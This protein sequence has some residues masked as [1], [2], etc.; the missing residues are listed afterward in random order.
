MSRLTLNIDDVI[1]RFKNTSRSNCKQEWEVGT[2]FHCNFIIIISHPSKPFIPMNK[3]TK[4]IF[5]FL[6]PMYVKYR[7]LIFTCNDV[8]FGWKIW[9]YS[10]CCCFVHIDNDCI[11]WWENDFLLLCNRF[12]IQ[13]HLRF[14]FKFSIEYLLRSVQCTVFEYE[15]EKCL[16]I[17]N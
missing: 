5:H 7:L 3:L 2:A 1:H 4:S 17:E 12:R 15:R 8:C 14:Y 13:H 11:I 9:R 16:Y 10:W 6:H